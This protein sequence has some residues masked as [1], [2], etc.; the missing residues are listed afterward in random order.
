M[1]AEPEQSRAGPGGQ[2]Q[3]QQDIEHPDSRGHQP[4]GP[5]GHRTHPSPG[6]RDQRPANDPTAA[7]SAAGSAAATV[8]TAPI[9]ARAV[10]TAAT[11]PILARA[12]AT[13]TAEPIVARALA[14]AAAE[15]RASTAVAVPI[16]AD[17]PR[18][19]GA[20]DRRLSI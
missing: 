6:C 18:N 16:L 7:G 15:P 14:P 1:V 9:L 4:R 17:D 10:A 19:G 13:A 12:V 2:R 3:R 8:A 20:G 5:R 11:A